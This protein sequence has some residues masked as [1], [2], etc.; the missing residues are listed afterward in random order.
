MQTLKIKNSNH[1]NHM[2]Q[3]HELPDNF[4]NEFAFSNIVDMG[5]RF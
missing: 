2:P 4:I 5:S 3:K 1:P